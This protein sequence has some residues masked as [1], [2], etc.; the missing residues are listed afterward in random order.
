MET[1]SMT[2]KCK[3]ASSRLETALRGTKTVLLEFYADWCPHCQRMMPVVER[4]RSNFG[5]SLEI[6]QVEGDRNAKLMASYGADSYPTWIIF[7]D[8]KEVWRNA[9]E[10]TIH[11]LQDALRR[12]V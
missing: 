8:G 1:A 3:S 5:D 10:K 7:K 9:G 12:F 6:V 4:I 11:E 2:T